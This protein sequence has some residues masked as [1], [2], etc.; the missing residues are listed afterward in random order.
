MSPRLNIPLGS[1]VAATILAFLWLAAPAI[2]HF[3]M[4]IPS[5]PTVM[6]TANSDLTVELKFW[7]PF[8]NNGMNLVKPKSLQVFTAD[9]PTDVLA[10]IKEVKQ[11]GFT[12]W[13]L[14]YKIARPGLYS[15]VMEPQP[16]WEPEEDCFIIHYTKAYV[17]AY[18]DDEGWNEPLGL[19]TEIVPL[20]KPGG[21]YAGNVFT[22]RVLLDGKAVNSGEVEIEWYPGPTLA[23]VAPYETM[24]T[25]V[26]LTD[27]NG[28]FHF[29][30]TAPGWW[31][32]AALNTADYKLP[33][34]GAQKDVELGA[35]LW[36]YFHEFKPAVKK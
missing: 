20:A 21:Q 29:S 3:G 17:D 35:V 11:D 5:A 33:Q 25:Q 19:K 24:I 22:G 23:G 2:A 32:F 12:T 4:V 9:G 31:G 8:E 14:P 34:D 26:V 27:E 30:P 10:S 13:S 18:G 28:L 16:Y 15:F 7:H 1:L 6:E 36:I